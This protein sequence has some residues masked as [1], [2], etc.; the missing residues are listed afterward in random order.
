MLVAKAQSQ[1]QM[2]HIMQVILSMAMCMDWEDQLVR[3]AVILVLVD[4]ALASP[5]WSTSPTA[6]PVPAA[7]SGTALLVLLTVQPAPILAS[8]RKPRPPHPALDAPLALIRQPA[9]RHAR[10]AG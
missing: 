9:R 2:P 1:F 3:M 10:Y 4:S 5:A 6:S 8:R 7:P